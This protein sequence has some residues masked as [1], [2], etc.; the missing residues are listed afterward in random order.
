[1]KMRLKIKNNEAH[2]HPHPQQQQQQL[3]M[4]QEKIEWLMD[5]NATLRK[6]Q[7]ELSSKVALMKRQL[8]ELRDQVKALLAKQQNNNKKEQEKAQE[9]LEMEVVR[10]E[11]EPAMPTATITTTP[12]TNTEYQQI[13]M[14]RKRKCVM[15]IEEKEIT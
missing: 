11:I 3:E 13:E 5:E 1:M 9:N 8:D 6:E 2:P 15:I 4:L 10:E 12:N 7:N 14:S